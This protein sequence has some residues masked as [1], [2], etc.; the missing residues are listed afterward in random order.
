M[1][2]EV[3]TKED[4]AGL[5]ET[6]LEQTTFKRLSRIYNH[7]EIMAIAEL[8]NQY[9]NFNPR[10]IEIMI[11]NS[12][13]ERI[14]P[15]FRKLLG[16]FI[17]YE[18]DIFGNGLIVIT[19]GN[20][21][22]T[23]SDYI[24]ILINAS[25]VLGSSRV[26]EFIFSW[27]KGDTVRFQEIYLLEGITVEE[28]LTLQEGF[29]IYQLPKSSN[30]LARVLPPESL[31]FYGILTMTCGVG[32]SIECEAGP[33]LCK[34]LNR[35]EGFNELY[36]TRASGLIEN[37]S[38]DN[39]CDA[40]SLAC[41]G[42]VQ[43]RV[44]FN[45]M[46]DIKYFTR[47][48]SGMAWKDLPVYFG[49]INFTQE[50]FENA[51][52]ILNFLIAKVSSIPSL[53]IAIKRWVKS[54]D[55]HSSFTDQLIDLRIALEVL[56]L[57][58]TNSELKFRMACRGAWHI[59]NKIKERKEIFEILIKTYNLA[60]N[61]VHEG[62]VDDTQYNK[63]LFAKAQNICRNGILKRLREETEPEWNDLIMGI[64]S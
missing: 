32:L 46:G 64:E 1:T 15:I 25:L 23:L 24:K 28:P 7:K 45:E 22:P 8:D 16:R 58:D 39:L 27:I 4:L 21:T 41:N 57:N 13:L 36:L 44:K 53:D 61:A 50:N 47:V 3:T 43:Y 62:K 63:N 38:I 18:T 19:G 48:Y 34:P 11:P 56:Y 2:Q 9:G 14:L 12:E 51:R 59:A 42:C 37:L 17:D 40:M 49:T 35:K 29:K 60:S 52:E 54:K 6:I 55:S 30:E 26:A 5:L 33:A 31:E 20:I 10:L